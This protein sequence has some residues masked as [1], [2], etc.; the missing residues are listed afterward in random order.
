MR[1]SICITAAPRVE[2]AP[3]SKPLVPA[4]M[5]TA[6]C[7]AASGSG[8][9][10]A[11][12]PVA[13]SHKQTT[14][15]DEE[16]AKRCDAIAR[17]PGRRVCWVAGERSSNGGCGTAAGGGFVRARG[18]A[19][20]WH[21]GNCGARATVRPPASVSQSLA[22]SSTAGRG[23]SV[24]PNCGPSPVGMG[25]GG[26]GGAGTRTRPVDTAGGG[27]GHCGGGVAGGG[28]AGKTASSGNSSTS[29]VACIT[30][31]NSCASL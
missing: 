22:A 3:A 23:G 30:D 11:P 26:T 29:K 9:E 8:G 2:R 28:G 20:S 13:C 16:P 12:P 27:R 21:C 1:M 18:G 25:T 15:I 7:L 6:V 24:I 10:V 19:K 17:E 31:S 4:K 14:S 5:T